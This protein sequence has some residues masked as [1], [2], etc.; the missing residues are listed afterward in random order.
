VIKLANYLA[1]NN[2]DIE[3]I[4]SDIDNR[5]ENIKE[6]AREM[7]TDLNEDDVGLVINCSL[8]ISKLFFETTKMKT[9]L[10]EYDG[11]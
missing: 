2:E 8:E 4:F 7:V 1:K 5:L 9:E 6:K 3:K 10:N 11:E